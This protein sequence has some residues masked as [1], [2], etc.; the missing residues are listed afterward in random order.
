M[1][2]FE[3]YKSLSREF[4][5]T[6]PFIKKVFQDE[7]IVSGKEATDKAFNMKIVKEKEVEQNSERIPHPLGWG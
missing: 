2:E 5:V 4:G 7:G 1:K 3:N 6:V